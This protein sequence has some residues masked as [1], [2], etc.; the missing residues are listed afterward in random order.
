MGFLFSTQGSVEVRKIYQTWGA[1]WYLVREGTWNT[2][3]GFSAERVN[4]RWCRCQAIHS[5]VHSFIR[6][7]IHWVISTENNSDDWGHHGI[8]TNKTK[9]QQNTKG[10]RMKGYHVF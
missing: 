9:Q 8:K 2:V 6:S 10:D 1:I 7:F 4:I 3:L 5:F